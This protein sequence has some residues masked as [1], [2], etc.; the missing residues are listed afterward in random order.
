M[1]RLF[2]WISGFLL[3]IGCNDDA[4]NRP[5]NPNANGGNPNVIEV[6]EREAQSRTSK[7]GFYSD[8]TDTNR[9][10]WNKPEMVIELL[11]DLSEKTVADIGAGTGFFS[12]RLA[13]AAKKVIA[14]D[15]DPGLVN[16]LDSVRVLQLKPEFA[17]RL[18]PRL[19]SATDPELQPE[20]VD[21]VVVANTY[22]YINNRV[23]YLKNLMRG[24]KPGAQ[25]LI[26][27]FKKKRI[28]VGPDS[29]YKVT[30]FEV[31]TELE[32]AGFTDIRSNDRLL[33]YQ[34]L[35]QARRPG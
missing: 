23:D 27:D 11:G 20:E 15:I 12:M 9:S 35:V 34:Y 7:E 19:A 32:R 31:E 14:I 10:I 6:T 30:L 25:L 29:R 8:Y 2:F 17:E 4:V 33:D 5:A 21:A 16:Y 18:E 13:K 3:C 1:T 24:M 28:P 26:I 22:M